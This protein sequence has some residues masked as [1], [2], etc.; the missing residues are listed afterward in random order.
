MHGKLFIQLSW[1]PSRS[2][3]RSWVNDC[4]CRR[5]LLEVT[6]KQNMLLIP[7]TCN[8]QICR[9]RIKYACDPEPKQESVMAALLIA[10]V[11][12]PK[13]EL[14]PRPEAQSACHKMLQ[15]TISMRRRRRYKFCDSIWNKHNRTRQDAEAA[16]GHGFPS[17][18]LNAAN[19]LRSTCRLYS[20]LCAQSPIGNSHSAS[21]HTSS[22]LIFQFQRILD[23]QADWQ[24]ARLDYRQSGRQTALLSVEAEVSWRVVDCFA[25][26]SLRNRKHQMRQIVQLQKDVF[27]PPLDYEMR[28][29]AWHI[30]FYTVGNA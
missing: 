16:F 21:A 19:I 26:I 4:I 11:R 25:M 29:I 14:L 12:A 2:Q 7:A 10:S 3:H 8:G 22:T 24:A 17:G 23:R 18:S 30:Y 6:Q 28:S 5:Q 15:E 9:R 1:L 20:T 27:L 13:P